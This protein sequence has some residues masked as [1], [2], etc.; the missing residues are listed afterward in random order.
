MVREH[1]WQLPA[2]TFQVVAITVYCLLVVAFYAFFAPF[3]G[4]RIW[5]YVLVGAY[6]PMALS[7]FVLYVRCTAINPADPGIMFK[8]D[9]ELMHEAEEKHETSAVPGSTR[10][11][12]E[13]S[14][15]TRSCASAASQSSFAGANSS[16]KGSVESVKST[17]RV[18]SRRRTSV[19]PFFGGIFYGVFVH[20]DCRKQDEADDPEGT[21]EDALFCT[22]CNVEVRKCS[23]HCRSCD[24][25]V[26]GFDH[27]CRW[28]NNCVGRKNYVTFISLMAISLV[29]LVVEAGVG[30]GVLVR[31]F[32][33]KSHMEAEIVDKLGNGFTR[34]PFATVVGITTYEFVVAMRAMSEE[35]SIHEELPNILYSPSGSATTGFSGRSSLGLQYK[36]AWCT[37]P[38]VFVDYQ[39]EVAS[40]L[41]PGRVPSTVD[42]DATVLA[43]KSKKGPKKG[44]KI[45][46]W[47]L[48]KLDSNEAVKAVAKARESSSVLRP[49]DNNSGPPASDLS[50]SENT[51]IRSSMSTENKDPRND[52]RLSPLGRLNSFASR[53]ELYETG[54]QS[55]SS[56]SSPSYVHEPVA[57]S[58]LPQPHGPSPIVVPGRASNYNINNPLNS[59]TC[60]LV[61]LDPA[62]QTASLFK[63]VKRT[64]VVWDQEAGRYVSVPLPASEARKIMSLP[65][66]GV[67]IN[68]HDNKLSAITPREAG[69]SE[70]LMYGG[71]SIF[72]GGPLLSGPMK[73]G[74][75]SEGVSGSGGGRGKLPMSLPR[76]SRFKRDAS[77]NQLPVFVPGNFNLNPPSESGL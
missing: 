72:F 61:F 8:F 46:A 28:L 45:S 68:N 56:F 37:P 38:R 7:V 44:V 27:H 60:P 35:A 53:D 49:I 70:K 33:N 30:I 20:E 9:P 6:S 26:D 57:L 63:D 36:G 64:S 55:L 11:F 47:K 54:T 39:E 23:K 75:R 42:P 17:A 65:N 62:S 48:A 51:S 71:E 10:K 24:K 34:V 29:W 16:K 41:G 31:C 67:A 76:E 15:V 13:V 12:D 19:C 32:V 52:Y 22:L 1:G 74:S 66:A 5:E 73:D 18:R 3:I 69:Q 25:C 50:S 77:S 4:G 43:D 58:P 40:Q 59:S 2:H 14:N 21:S